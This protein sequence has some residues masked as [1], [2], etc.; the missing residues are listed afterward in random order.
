M[1]SNG[2]EAEGSHA[3]A[4][5]TPRRSL[6]MG[7]AASVLGRPRAADTTEINKRAQHAAGAHAWTL[8]DE[9]DQKQ[10]NLNA[11]RVELEGAITLCRALFDESAD[12]QDL[13]TLDRAERILA[14]LAS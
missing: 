13:D 11:L 3:D 9:I 5:P 1:S 12:Q 2:S 8:C 10:Q 14:Q 6:R 4:L 7:A